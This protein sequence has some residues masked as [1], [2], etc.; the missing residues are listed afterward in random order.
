VSLT[1]ACLGPALAG[2]SPFA[3][4]D[5]GNIELTLRLTATGVLIIDGVLSFTA[6]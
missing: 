6:S 5:I 2:F 4:R 1:A 3:I